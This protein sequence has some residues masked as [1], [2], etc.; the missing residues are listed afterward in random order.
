VKAPLLFPLLQPEDI[1]SKIIKAVKKN[2]IILMQPDNVNLV[3]ILK[4]LFPPRVFDVVAG[5]LG[6]YSSM[7][8][9]EGRPKE[10]RIPVK[11]K[12]VK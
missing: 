9:F 7:S 8:S 12:T 4:G 1:S 6:V 5:W 10:E 2:E 3:P 11:K